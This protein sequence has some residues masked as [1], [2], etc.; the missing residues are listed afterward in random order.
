MLSAYKIGEI[1]EGVEK[2]YGFKSNSEECTIV[3]KKILT[4]REQKS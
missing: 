1:F 3:I 4:V 2:E